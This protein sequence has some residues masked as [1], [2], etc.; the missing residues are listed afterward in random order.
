VT[1][2]DKAPAVLAPFFPKTIQE[3]WWF[4]LTDKTKKEGAVKRGGDEGVTIHAIEKV[5]DQ[6]KVI[7]H[8]LRFMAPQQ[9]GTYHMQLHILSD[10]YKGLDELLEISFDVLPQ[11][12]LPEYLPHPEDVELDNEPS[13]FEQVMA[14]NQDV[15]SESDDDEQPSP[16]GSPSRIKQNQEEDDDDEEGSEED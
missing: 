11:A 12:D 13:L 16:K 3:G 9:A 14:A 10:A 2:G 4:I 5:T 6:G 15:D 1:D 7:K 8:E